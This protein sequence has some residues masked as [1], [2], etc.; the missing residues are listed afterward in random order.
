MAELLQS[1]WVQT[2]AFG[3]CLAFVM[4]LFEKLNGPNA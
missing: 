3:F 4:I 2:I 1:D